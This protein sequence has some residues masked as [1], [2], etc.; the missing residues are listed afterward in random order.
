MADRGFTIK[1][2]RMHL[3]ADE[4]KKGRQIASLR[5]HVEHAI[6]RVKQF[7]I[8]KDLFLPL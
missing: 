4:V 7:G 1:E 5:I 3:P 2:E 6:G 8:L